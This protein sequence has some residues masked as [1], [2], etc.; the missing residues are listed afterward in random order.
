MKDIEEKDLPDVSGGICARR[1]R[2]FRTS[3]HDLRGRPH[4]ADPEPRPEP[5]VSAAVLLAN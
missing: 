5:V 4:R 2:I 3:S 1:R